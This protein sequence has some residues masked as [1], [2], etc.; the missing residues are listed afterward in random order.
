MAHLR[1]DECGSSDTNAF[2]S[3]DTPI[4]ILCGKCS[5]KKKKKQT[6][7]DLPKDNGQQ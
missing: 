5:D 1:C 2:G 6:T 4:K 7:K 3:W